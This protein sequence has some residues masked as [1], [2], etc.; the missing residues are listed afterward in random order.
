MDLHLK[1]WILFRPDIKGAKVSASTKLL[2]RI[3][4]LSNVAF[5]T[6]PVCEASIYAIEERS[7]SVNC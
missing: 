2:A 4:V 5:D 7:T 6:H 1:L 3:V